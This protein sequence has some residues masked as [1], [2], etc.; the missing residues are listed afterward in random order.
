MAVS[1]ERGRSRSSS[2]LFIEAVATVHPLVY[3]HHC[4]R[5]M[6]SFARYENEYKLLNEQLL[7]YFRDLL[8]PPV[9]I[10]EA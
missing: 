5:R 2:K 4:S 9:A 8:A 7:F 3:L 10:G 1:V 6:K